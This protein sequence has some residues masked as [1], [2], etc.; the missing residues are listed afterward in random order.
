M[1]TVYCDRTNCKHNS[2]DRC[3]RTEIKF[4][5][6]TFIVDTYCIS[7]ER[8][9]KAPVSTPAEQGAQEKQPS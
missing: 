8:K 4:K 3:Q 2:D 6:G 7:F 5:M 9:E 1:T